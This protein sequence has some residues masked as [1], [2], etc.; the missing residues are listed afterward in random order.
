MPRKIGRSGRDN[1]A[2]VPADLRDFEAGLVLLKRT[3]FPSNTPQPGGAT[4]ELLAALEESLVTDANPKK[5]ASPTAINT[6]PTRRRQQPPARRKAF[7]QIVEERPAPG[8]TTASA[9]QQNIPGALPV[10]ED[11]SAA[12]FL[13]RAF[14]TLRRFPESRN[15]TSAIMRGSDSR[16][17]AYV[18]ACFAGLALG[19]EPK[20]AARGVDIVA[21]F[22]AQS[23]GNPLL[24]QNP[25]K[26]LL[27]P[28]FG[29]PPRQTLDA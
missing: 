24:D 13:R 27:G 23:G 20:L 4:V 6:P 21:F 22:P 16:G 1:L 10:T 9:G 19:F 29:T 2:C 11:T 25:Q 5:R 7:K 28:G 15:P 14:S 18:A 8:S 26:S 12:D 17:G 3:T